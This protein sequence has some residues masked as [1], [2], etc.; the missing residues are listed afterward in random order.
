VSA[1]VR[2]E[3]FI[4]AFVLA[5]MFAGRIR[6]GAAS[7]SCHSV[8][9][10]V[11]RSAVLRCRSQP[12]WSIWIPK[13]GNP[14][15]NHLYFGGVLWF[16][17]RPPSHERNSVMVRCL[18]LT[19]I[20]ILGSKCLQKVIKGRLL[21]LSS[22]KIEIWMSWLTRSFKLNWGGFDHAQYD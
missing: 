12:R 6:R 16:S 15:L 19:Y 1:I 3:A 8:F 21:R 7:V 4:R 9:S 18:S 20:V 10:D 13:P 11:L 22:S 2:S 5:F 17:R 14:E